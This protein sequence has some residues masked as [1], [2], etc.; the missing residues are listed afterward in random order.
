[1]YQKRPKNTAQIYF[2][3]EENVCFKILT[4]IISENDYTYSTTEAH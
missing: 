1:M 4:V 3:F 2:V